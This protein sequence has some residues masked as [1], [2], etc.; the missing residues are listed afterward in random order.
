MRRRLGGVSSL[1]KPHPAFILEKGLQEIIAPM[2]N[3]AT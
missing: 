2:T 1:V 3:V